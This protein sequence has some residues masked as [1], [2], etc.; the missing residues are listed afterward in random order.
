MKKNYKPLLDAA[1]ET[2][3]NQLSNSRLLELQSVLS[4][5]GVLSKSSENDIDISFWENLEKRYP[6]YYVEAFKYLHTSGIEFDSKCF[7]KDAVESNIWLIDEL[8]K[9][10]MPL[11][12]VFLCAGW[13]ATLA[14]MMFEHKINL[15]KIRSFD[16]DPAAITISEIFNRRWVI[17]NWKF[18][19][20]KSNI[21]DIDFDT[22]NYDVLRS[23]GT[24]CNLTD[25]VDTV[26]N[27]NCEFTENSVKWFSNI[28]NGTLV[29]LQASN[30]ITENQPHVFNSFREF[31]QAFPT[32]NLLY[33]DEKKLDNYTK[34]MKIGFK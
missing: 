26:I 31:D 25:D 20:A 1:T 33:C 22:H 11:G 23:N 9:I 7:D 15:I 4:T 5:T 29:V 14:V 17:D 30:R 21:A 6:T 13:Y 19:S 24:V 18:K 28:L 12:T 16:L 8:K 3:N 2:D 10:K 27:T 34:Y 32:N